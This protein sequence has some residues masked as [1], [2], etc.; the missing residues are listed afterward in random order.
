MKNLLVLLCLLHA[1]LLATSQ[2]QESNDIFWPGDYVIGLQDS[3]EPTVTCFIKVVRY[4]T[5][6]PRRGWW[7]VPPI[8]PPEAF[9]QSVIFALRFKVGKNEFTA[10]LSSYADLA[11]PSDTEIRRVNHGYSLSIAGGDAG[12][13]YQVTIDFNDTTVISRKVRYDEYNMG[14]YW[15]ETEYHENTIVDK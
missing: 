8:S 12:C 9:P 6:M 4:S 2:F 7:S 14:H 15:E 11:N 5:A 1:E 3:K 13:T 10:P